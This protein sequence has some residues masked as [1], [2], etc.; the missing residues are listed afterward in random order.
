MTNQPQ[1]VRKW[2][3]LVVEDDQALSRIYHEKLSESG[4]EVKDALDGDEGL[5]LA[6]KE[7]PDLIVLDLMLPKIDGMT[8]LRKL[9]DDEWGRN[10]P[11]IIFSNL[12]ENDVRLKD[13]T[14]YEPAYYLLKSDY[15]LL[16]LVLKIQEVLADTKRQ[17]QRGVE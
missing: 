10:V 15:T 13:V 17:A 5:E 14:K 3:I 1:A 7:H 12:E 11:V 6:L 8:V 16:D 4:F 2:R 9:R